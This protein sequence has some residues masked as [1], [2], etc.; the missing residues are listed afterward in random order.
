MQRQGGSHIPFVGYA[1]SPG[2]MVAEMGGANPYRII[3]SATPTKEGHATV[4]LSLAVPSPA[5]GTQP[6]RDACLFLLQHSKDGLEKDNMI[7]EHLSPDA[8]PHFTAR[9]EPVI[10]FRKFCQDFME[11]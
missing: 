8:P 2:I 5:D 4:R 11:N 3:T 10:E 9:D 6:N 1:Y 7:W